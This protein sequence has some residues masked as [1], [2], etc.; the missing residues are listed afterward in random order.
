V[1]PVSRQRIGKHIP[2]AS[3]TNTTIELLLEM[4]FSTQSVQ[5]GY[6]EDNSGDPVRCQL[7]RKS[8]PLKRRLGGCCEM[9]AS[10]GVSCQLSVS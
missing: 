4:A 8:Q 3:N 7:S 10:L 1:Q 2:A 9:A 6:K 5:S